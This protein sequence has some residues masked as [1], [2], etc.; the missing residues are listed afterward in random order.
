MDGEGVPVRGGGGG[1][2]P[3][4]WRVIPRLGGGSGATEREVPSG[5]GSGDV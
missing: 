1:G 4:G 5:Q 3:G 2:G